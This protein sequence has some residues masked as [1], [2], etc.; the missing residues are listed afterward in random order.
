[1]TE[2][3]NNVIEQAFDESN[4]Y[5][6]DDLL[7]CFNAAMDS[8]QYEGDDGTIYNVPFGFCF[9]SNDDDLINKVANE[10]INYG[11]PIKLVKQF[12]DDVINKDFD[13]VDSIQYYL[14]KVSSD[15]F[16]IFDDDLLL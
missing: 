13:L 1:M 8:E 11:Y 14:E 9:N 6:G 7:V 2:E 5:K 15:N 4:Y 3:L 12:K 16:L 10:M